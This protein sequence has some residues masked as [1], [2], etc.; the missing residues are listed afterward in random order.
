MP[1][2]ARR[3]RWTDLCSRLR[4]IAGDATWF[5]LR[6]DFDT[7]VTETREG[8]DTLDG[9]HALEGEINRLA[10]TE[11]DQIIRHGDFGQEGFA[12]HGP[13]TTH[14]CP[15]ALCD[16]LVRGTPGVAPACPLFGVP[17]PEVT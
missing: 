3:A 12:V 1:E 6:A 7:L 9:W 17:M 8:T 16:R 13:V 5:G 2:N 15:R 14:R 4:H 10:A 11:V